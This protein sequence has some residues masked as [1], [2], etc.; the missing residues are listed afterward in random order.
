VGSRS[1]SYGSRG[2]RESRKSGPRLSPYIS[3]WRQGLAKLR[4]YYYRP[5]VKEAGCEVR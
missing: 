5:S 3:G 4:E 2:I 1:N